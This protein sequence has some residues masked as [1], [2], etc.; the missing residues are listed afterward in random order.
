MDFGQWK[1]WR[2]SFEEW[3]ATTG[4]ELPSIGPRTMR[5]LLTLA[6]DRATLDGA[7]IR[8]CGA[9]HSEAFDWGYALS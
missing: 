5:A 3:V 6:V 2:S 1:A 7:E 8:S 4:Y 9:W